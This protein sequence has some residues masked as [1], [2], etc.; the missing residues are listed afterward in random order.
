MANSNLLVLFIMSIEFLSLIL[1]LIVL[2][3]ILI[4]II[5]LLIR[6]V[7]HNLCPVCGAVILKWHP[8]YCPF[9]GTMFEKKTGHER[10]VR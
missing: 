9:C 8:E 7:E 3:V 2:V 1:Y 10:L 5:R 4:V 6:V